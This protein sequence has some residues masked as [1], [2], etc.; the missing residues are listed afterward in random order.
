MSD[1]WARPANRTATS[2]TQRQ[3]VLVQTLSTQ[4]SCWTFATRLVKCSGSLARS[5]AIGKWQPQQVATTCFFCS[6]RQWAVTGAQ[7]HWH[8]GM[9]R[10]RKQEEQNTQRGKNVRVRIVRSRGRPQRS[11]RSHNAHWSAKGCSMVQLD[12]SV[13]LENVCQAH[14]TTISHAVLVFLTPGK[15]GFFEGSA[16]A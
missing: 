8:R 16:A 14:S 12:S 5:R 10:Q 7:R 9:R 13:E 3:Q 1:H 2:Y 15:C 11:R 6:Q 4:E